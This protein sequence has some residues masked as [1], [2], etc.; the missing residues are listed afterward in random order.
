MA[1]QV[2]EAAVVV[3]TPGQILRS[4]LPFDRCEIVLLAGPAPGAAWNAS[5]LSDMWRLTLPHVRRALVAPAG[6]AGWLPGAQELR[7]A[8]L[9]VLHCAD[10]A[11]SMAKSIA[12]FWPA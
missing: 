3:M 12:D 10:N 5:E 7:P 11:E 1:S 2:I 4:G 8:S 9:S 6:L